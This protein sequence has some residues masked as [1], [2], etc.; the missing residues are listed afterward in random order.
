MS[1]PA[2]TSSAFPLTRVEDI[3]GIILNSPGAWERFYKIYERYILAITARC[4]VVAHRRPEVL[5][6]VL[7]KVWTLCRGFT[8][9]DSGDGMNF[10]VI[11]PLR[12]EV[13]RRWA[14]SLAEDAVAGG[15]P[16]ANVQQRQ[17]WT[18]RMQ[19]S[20]QG[21]M[22]AFVDALPPEIAGENSGMKVAQHLS[23]LL[24]EAAAGT[25]TEAA[26]QPNRYARFRYWLAA[27]VENE[28]RHGSR[29]SAWEKR[30]QSLD[31]EDEHGQSLVEEIVGEHPAAQQDFAAARD[32]LEAALDL[33]RS[34]YRSPNKDTH[35][36]WFLQRKLDG[37][38]TRELAAASP[39]FS[40][41]TINQSI[42]TVQHLLR[43]CAAELSAGDRY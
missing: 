21:E 10:S 22:A 14:A 5:N 18:K 2:S 3:E 8:Y 9:R 6:L 39:G 33:A 28:C 7:I 42:S 20:M 24:I 17:A 1:S 31:A 11:N 36:A 13:W 37:V 25:L 23:D 16:A 19:T 4:G 15:M 34:R 40:E 12:Q 43:T 27:V 26:L 29:L 35:F 41:A 32:L 38:S 30:V